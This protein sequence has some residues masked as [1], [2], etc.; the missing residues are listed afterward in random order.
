MSFDFK[1]DTPIYLQIIEY[2]KVQII[3]GKYLPGERLPSV[4][5]LSLLFEVNPNT[6]QKALVELES[7][8]LLVTERTNGKFV[9]KND[10]TIKKYREQA[11]KDVATDFFVK[12]EKLGVDRE[13]VLEMIEK[14]E[15]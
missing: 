2:V 5:D 9:T 4:R 13:R 8:G 12:M 6:V 10:D 3:N 7:M 14:G 11:I 15:L 1:N